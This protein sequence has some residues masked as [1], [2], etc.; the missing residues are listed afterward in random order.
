MTEYYK[1]KDV[2]D[3]K[4]A[5][6]FTNKDVKVELKKGPKGV[7]LFARKPIRKGNIV[8]YYK[9]KVYKDQQFK[10]IKSNMYSIAVYNKSG[11]MS[12]KFIGDIY[13]GSLSVPKRGISFL[14]YFSNE[15]SD[16]QEQNCELD[17]NLE[18][19]YRNRDR[20]KEGDTMIYKLVATQNISKGEEVCWC[21]SSSYE[22][23][24]RANCE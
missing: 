23:D 20:V 3:Y 13:G 7:S 6:K 16:D 5:R 18:S 14:A 4:F 9:F 11:R 12:E 24:Y 22:R 8:A 19:N 10:G 2:L 15:P 17:L 21:Y 1:I